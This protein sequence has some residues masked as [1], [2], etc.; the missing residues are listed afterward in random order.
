MIYAPKE[1]AQTRPEIVAVVA[2]AAVFAVAHPE[3]RAAGDQPGAAGPASPRGR[4]FRL[5]LPPSPVRRRFLGTQERPRT[6]YGVVSEVRVPSNP[7]PVLRIVHAGRQPPALILLSGVNAKLIAPAILARAN[8][9]QNL[10]AARSGVNRE[11]VV[12]AADGEPLGTPNPPLLLRKLKNSG[13]GLAGNAR[14][15]LGQPALLSRDKAAELAAFAEIDGVVPFV[16][17]AAGGPGFRLA[18]G[19]GL[20]N[21][22]V[23]G[24]APVLRQ[25]FQD[26]RSP[27]VMGKGLPIGTVPRGSPGGLDKAI[28]G[29]QQQKRAMPAIKSLGIRGLPRSPKNPKKFAL[30]RKFARANFRPSADNYTL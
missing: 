28:P 16:M 21:A 8:Q 1:K 30:G 11:P 17:V 22:A 27:V 5:P 13:F 25:G 20:V 4:N 2:N 26:S 14:F 3:R 23:K 12:V 7:A 29:P 6:I 9:P 10:P 15:P 18:K 19:I 24:L